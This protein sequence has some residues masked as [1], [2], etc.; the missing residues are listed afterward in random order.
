[1]LRFAVLFARLLPMNFT[2]S[3]FATVCWAVR[4]EGSIAYNSVIQALDSG[5]LES[6]ASALLNG[7]EYSTL[8]RKDGKFVFPEVPNGNYFLEIQSVNYIF[9]KIRVD[10]NDDGVTGA[11]SVLGSEWDS[12]G[13]E[14][15]YPFTIKA[16]AET[17]YF[18]A[19][20]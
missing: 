15:P 14:V 12:T 1:M 6:T 9:P 17:E 7:G 16:K 11:Y 20:V 10:I 3:L 2:C 19:S 18:M 8:I 4:L 5:D 13:Y